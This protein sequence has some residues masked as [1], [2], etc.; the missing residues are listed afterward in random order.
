MN[1]AEPNIFIPREYFYVFEGNRN[2][3][4]NITLLPLEERT[5][6][7]SIVAK[8]SRRS[9]KFL[10]YY[11]SIPQAHVDDPI[12][13]VLTW[14]QICITCFTRSHVLSVENRIDLLKSFE[15]TWHF[16]LYFVA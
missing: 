10:Y 4:P 12:R 11:K 3:G 2:G 14:D 6:L 15:L 8:I 9:K 1:Y 13:K 16:G 5:A 7:D